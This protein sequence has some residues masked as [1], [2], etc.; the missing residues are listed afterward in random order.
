M[1]KPPRRFFLLSIFALL[2]GST[3]VPGEL[4]GAI[5]TGIS[6]E[7]EVTEIPASLD[8]GDFIS[9]THIRLMREGPGIVTPVMPNFDPDGAY[10]DPSLPNA[11]STFG[12]AITTPY[13]G[14]GLPAAGSDVYSV[15]LHFDPDVSDLPFSLTQ[16]IEQSGTITFDRPIL[17]VYVT[18]EALDATDDIFTPSGVTF[19]PDD[20]RDMEFN[21][22]GDIYA[23]SPDRY[24]LSLTMFGHNGGYFDEM[25]V[26]LE[27]VSACPGDLDGS[28][29]VDSGD[30]PIFADHFGEDGC[31]GVCVGDIEPAYGDGDFDG[32][33]LGAVSDALLTGC[34]AL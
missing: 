20:R 33:D 9:Q 31:G 3:A 22:D 23:I 16:G 15:L 14:P 30:L 5:I 29:V 27:P 28:G 19:S 32:L 25:R 11:G 1:M 26:I 18:S 2:I 34:P 4:N 17:G 13:S 24:E 7:I 10:H 21:Y 6:G 8:A 12:N